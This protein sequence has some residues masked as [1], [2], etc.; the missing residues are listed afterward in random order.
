MRIGRSGKGEWSWVFGEEVEERQA[1]AR[2][3]GP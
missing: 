1:R 2:L 3:G